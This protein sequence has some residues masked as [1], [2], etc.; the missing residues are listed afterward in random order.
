MANKKTVKIKAIL[1]VMFL[2]AFVLPNFAAETVEDNNTVQQAEI[3][4]VEDYVNNTVSTEKKIIPENVRQFIED[5]Y[6]DAEFR[7]DGS[8][9]LPDGT[10]YIPLLPAKI[11]EP[12]KIEI[13]SAY[14]KGKTLLDKPNIVVLNNNFVLL[15]ILT[16]TK[17][18]KTI[19]K[20]ANPPQELRTGML[21]KHLF[22]P[23]GFVIPENLKS[24][25][26]DLN[27]PTVDDPTIKVQNNKPVV[28]ALS[29]STLNTLS[30]IPALS[31]KNFYVSSPYSKSIQVLNLGAKTPEYSLKQP[32]IPIN[33]KSYDDEYLLV[34]VYD[35]NF[36]DVISLADDAVIKQ[37]DVKSQPDQIII[38]ENKKIAYISCPLNSSIYLVNL[39]TMTLF[40]QIKIIGMCEKITLSDDGTKLFYYDKAHR[41]IW[42]VEL[43]NNYLLKEIGKF[44]NV[45]KIV[46]A[47]NKL[48]ITSR[49]KNRIAVIDY[50]TV[51]LIA[52]FEICDKPID[53]ISFDN[54][55]FVLGAQ[56]NSIQVIDTETDEITDSIYLNTDG[57]STKI[58][59][60]N[61]T[62]IALITDTK[63]SLYTVFDLK[64]KK[65]ISV[66]PIDIPSKS[67]VA[68][69]KVKKH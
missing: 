38:D 58:E 5:S 24:V 57:F 44:P 43:D 68:V 61:D 2:G 69:N 27:I 39:E 3:Q 18:Q 15:K 12:D 59:R 9:I 20:M 8:V 53:M 32:N 28:S 35:K 49:T 36:V 56:D 21:P 16:D 4:K 41:D 52:E 46:Y 10:I 34:S 30:K 55:V 65:V 47:D 19:Y 25:I 50:D 48:Y 33:L 62:N 42:A 17:G 11:I 7:F 60:I 51:G 6:A 63:A 54:N 66:V 40:K 13:V 37:I 14:P 67:I 29:G 45:S 23:A 22:V 31:N 64:D 26:G 1:V